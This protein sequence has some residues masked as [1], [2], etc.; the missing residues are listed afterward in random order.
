MMNFT[1][2]SMFMNKRVDS[3]DDSTLGI[4]YADG[5]PICFVIEDEYREEKVSGETRIPQGSYWLEIR[6]EVTP[7]TQ[8]YR[9]K[10]TWFEYHIEVMNVKGFTGI[11]FHVG[12]FE[13]DTAGCQIIGYDA[14]ITDDNEF[15][16]INSGV[17][18][19]EF[20]KEL[21]PILDKGAKI[22]YTIINLD[23]T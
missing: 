4:L 13:G 17:C 2:N 19:E 11:Y 14:G 10:Y 16:N 20:Y 7:L 15:R 21:Y 1:K 23:I 9:D 6:R 3:T 5:K 12:N 22:P 8:K 18:Y